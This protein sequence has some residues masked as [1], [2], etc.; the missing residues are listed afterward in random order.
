MSLQSTSR[1]NSNRGVLKR[2]RNSD[3]SPYLEPKTEDFTNNRKNNYVTLQVS[4]RSNSNLLRKS[5]RNVTWS[6]KRRSQSRNKEADP[7]INSSNSNI[8]VKSYKSNKEK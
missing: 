2:D 1:D 7:E 3:R 8:S 4:G 6:Q 5:Q